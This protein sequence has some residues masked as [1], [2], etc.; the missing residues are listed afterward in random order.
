MQILQMRVCVRQ[1][2]SATDFKR[3]GGRS[4]LHGNFGD[5]SGSPSFVAVVQSA[6]LLTSVSAGTKFSLGTVGPS[7]VAMKRASLNSAVS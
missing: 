2:G 6:H 3:P 4:S 5:L 1:H 7:V